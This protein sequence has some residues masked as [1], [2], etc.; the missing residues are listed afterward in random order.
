MPT[1]NVACELD[2]LWLSWKSG[3]FRQRGLRFKSRQQKKLNRN[4]YLLLTVE[5]TKVKKK[6]T[7]MAHFLKKTFG[8]Q[9]ETKNI[10]YYFQDTSFP[11]SLEGV[12]KLNSAVT[13]K[14][15]FFTL[16]GSAPVQW[17]KRRQRNGGGSK[18]FFSV[19]C[20]PFIRSRR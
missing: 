4:M 10:L 8:R 2:R 9:S 20:P 6:R 18:N 12:S 14:T 3:R 1:S 7:R 5:K 11:H 16:S 15:R 13:P 17:Q 19:K